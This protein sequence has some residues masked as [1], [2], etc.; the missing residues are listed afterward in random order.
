MVKELL[1][2]LQ[3]HEDKP[4]RNWLGMTFEDHKKAI[5][6]LNHR[7]SYVYKVI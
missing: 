6:N 1:Y 3:N 5:L 4:N 7:G 2:Y